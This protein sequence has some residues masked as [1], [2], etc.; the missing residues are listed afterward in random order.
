MWKNFCI[1]QKIAVIKEVQGLGR[2][3]LNDIDLQMSN[4]DRVTENIKK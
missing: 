3:Y 2:V 1:T 4:V